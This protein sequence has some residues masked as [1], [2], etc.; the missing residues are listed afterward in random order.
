[1]RETLEKTKKDF[2]KLLD[3]YLLDYPDQKE[4]VEAKKIEIEELYNEAVN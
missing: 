3:E 4:W 2:I 1:M